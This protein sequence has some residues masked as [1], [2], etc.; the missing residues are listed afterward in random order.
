[1]WAV[2]PGGFATSPSEAVRTPSR[3]AAESGSASIDRMGTPVRARIATFLVE[4]PPRTRW[5]LAALRMTLIRGAFGH[6]GRNTVIV[7]PER[8]RGAR[9]ITIG[10]STAIYEDAWLQAEPGGRLSIGD[11]VYIGRRAHFHAAGNVTI[12]S[13]CYIT[14][15]V[16]IS[17]GEHDR[18]QLDV[19]TSRG[20]IRLG[21][22]VFVGNGAMILGGVT[23]GDGAQIAARAVVTRDVPAGSTVAGTPA[24][25]IDRGDDS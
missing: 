11:G 21:E 25:V 13:G 4:L 14:D 23:V 16:V 10:E 5:K 18:R 3:D 2:R 24:K 19:V 8:I 22:R 7:R 15:E 20:D 6:V 1:M 17:D 12:G 9:G